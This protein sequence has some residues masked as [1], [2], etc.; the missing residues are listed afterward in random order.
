MKQAYFV[1]SAHLS[2]MA[3][4]GALTVKPL[5]TPIYVKRKFTLPPPTL[6]KQVLNLTKK[7]IRFSQLNQLEKS[8]VATLHQMGIK[9]SNIKEQ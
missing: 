5:P 7:G 8:G 3:Q 4:V 1:C 6:V 9:P 2:E